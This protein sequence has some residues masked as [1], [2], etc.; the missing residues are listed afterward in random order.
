MT[1]IM[2]SALGLLGVI[3]AVIILACLLIDKPDEEEEYREM[4]EFLRW[5]NN[6]EKK[7]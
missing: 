6:K 1:D 3:D 5:K 4:E 2:I 7:G